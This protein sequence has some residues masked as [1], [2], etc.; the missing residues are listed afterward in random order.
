MNQLVAVLNE[1][2]EAVKHPVKTLKD[3][4]NAVVFIYGLA[5]S[6]HSFNSVKYSIK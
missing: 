2:T 5:G 3:I 4:C 6:V 1:Q